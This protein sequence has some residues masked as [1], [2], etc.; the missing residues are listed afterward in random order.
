MLLD[1]AMLVA[2]IGMVWL[3]PKMARLQC[4][5]DRKGAVIMAT[6]TFFAIV[7]YGIG[8]SGEAWLIHWKAW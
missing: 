1:L 8:A 4:D 2:V 3:V 6:F 7:I 5:Q